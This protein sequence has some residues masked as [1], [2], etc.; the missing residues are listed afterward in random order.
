[1]CCRTHVFLRDQ[2]VGHAN[3]SANSVDSPKRCH[4]NDLK[5]GREFQRQLYSQSGAVRVAVLRD[6]GG[7]KVRERAVVA[8]G[9]MDLVNV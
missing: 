1:M 5:R 8:I 3:L 2:P 9:W 6:V 7:A 4:K